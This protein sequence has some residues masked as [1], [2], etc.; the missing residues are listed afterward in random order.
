MLD[1]EFSFPSTLQKKFR[2]NSLKVA[3]LLLNNL[4]FQE[5]HLDNVNDKYRF[6]SRIRWKGKISERLLKNNWERSSR[7][8]NLHEIS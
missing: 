6:A 4:R 8:K 5:E 1:R 3:L 2:K 7:N